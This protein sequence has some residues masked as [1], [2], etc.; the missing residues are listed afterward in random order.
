MPTVGA[1]DDPAPGYTL[2]ATHHRRFTTSTGVADDRTLPD[3]I[4]DNL[5]IVTLVEAKVDRTEPWAWGVLAR[6]VESR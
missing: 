6:S 5:V 2:N 4:I 3:A 1:L